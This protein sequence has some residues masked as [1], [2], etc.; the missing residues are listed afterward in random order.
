MNILKSFYDSLTQEDVQL[1]LHP[2]N[3]PKLKN[4]LYRYFMKSTGN[5]TEKEVNLFDKLFRSSADHKKEI[6]SLD[7]ISVGEV[8]A[9]EADGREELTYVMQKTQEDLLLSSKALSKDFFVPGKVANLYVFRPSSGGYL[10]HGTITRLNNN[11]VVFHYDGVIEK[12]GEAHLMLVAKYSL[13][14]SPWPPKDPEKESI[15][16]DRNKL[17]LFEENVD[18]QLELLKKI[19]KEQSAHDDDK[20]KFPDVAKSFTALSERI[21]DRGITFELPD[22]ISPE[23]WKAQDLWEV[24][25]GFPGGANFELRGKIFPVKQKG[26]LFLLRFVDADEASRKSIYEEIKKRGGTREILT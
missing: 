9:L 22:H 14:I 8:S 15:E 4:A 3:R 10:I 7:D 17:V 21:S 13:T 19:S 12:K 6:S 24:H 11:G 1:Y 20:F 5:P 26:D 2:E 23:I 16:L 18:K 25:F